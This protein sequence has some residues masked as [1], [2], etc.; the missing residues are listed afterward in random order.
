MQSSPG[1]VEVDGSHARVDGPGLRPI[2]I[3]RSNLGTDV[4][5]CIQSL[6]DFAFEE[7]LDEFL[8]LST[9]PLGEKVGAKNPCELRG[10]WSTIFHSVSLLKAGRC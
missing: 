3:A 2:A 8:E 1:H 6:L 4:L 5:G 9:D 10:D 7:D